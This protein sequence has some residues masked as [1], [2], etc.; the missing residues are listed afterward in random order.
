MGDVTFKVS[1]GMIEKS[2]NMVITSDDVID[3]DYYNAFLKLKSTVYREGYGVMNLYANNNILSLLTSGVS[4]NPKSLKILTDPD[5]LIGLTNI[6][7]AG[8][9][10]LS[11]EYINRYTRI[12]R[13]YTLD[14][15]SNAIYNERSAKLLRN[16]I[17]NL[18][19][20]V[21]ESLKETGLSEDYALI[22]TVNRFSST[23]ERRNIRRAVRAM[24]HIDQHI[25]TEQRVVDIFAKLFSEQLTNLFCAIMTDRFDDFD[26]YNEE[27]V[28]S[29]VSNALLDILNT[30]EVDEIKDIIMEYISELEKSGSIGRFRLNSINPTDYG[31]ITS[32]IEEIE[33]MGIYVY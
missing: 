1:S 13:A 8:E 26:D 12:Y 22:I 17:Y 33:M 15:S 31:N 21:V 29:T 3:K 32:A 28:Y 4:K 2:A 14:P 6:M 25:M 27:Y 11:R 5:F 30:M 18:N 23:E 20:D 9:L 16:I 24:Q 7:N 10:V 19:K